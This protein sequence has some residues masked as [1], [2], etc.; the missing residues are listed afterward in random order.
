[1][2]QL[3]D[4]DWTTAGYVT[5]TKDEDGYAWIEWIDQLHFTFPNT[6]HGK[7]P[8]IRPEAARLATASAVAW[9]AHGP[10]DSGPTEVWRGLVSLG[11]YR[12]IVDG[13]PVKAED[14]TAPLELTVGRAGGWVPAGFFVG[15]TSQSHE[16]L[17]ASMH[18]TVASLADTST[19]ETFHSLVPVGTSLL[20]TSTSG[21]HVSLRRVEDA[22]HVVPS[23]P[24][25]AFTDTL[26]HVVVAEGHPPLVLRVTDDRT[27]VEAAV[28][29][30][31]GT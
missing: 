21:P 15:V 2:H 12:V 3:F 16:L 18:N 4:L 5:M 7:I 28:V 29:L 26:D 14:T 24:I 11:G 23:D 8:G 27:R 1:V 31:E 17:L 6:G 10:T 19:A 30:C 13:F 9:A 20:M 25:Q 22:S